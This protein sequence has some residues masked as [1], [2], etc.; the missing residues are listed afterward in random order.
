MYKQNDKRVFFSCT[1]GYRKTSK[2]STFSAKL[3]EFEQENWEQIF[4]K[5]YYCSP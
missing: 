5:I 4:L 2:A 1:E 3:R